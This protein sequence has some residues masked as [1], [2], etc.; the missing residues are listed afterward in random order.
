MRV[1]A[2]LAVASLMSAAVLAEEALQGRM[3]HEGDK[4]KSRSTKYYTDKFNNGPE[5]HGEPAEFEGGYMVGAILGFLFTGIF[6]VFAVINSLWDE[7]KRHKFYEAKIRSDQQ[8]LQENYNVTP[9][10]IQF[11]IRE[12]E[13]K[14]RT[15]GVKKD[16]A[17][18]QAELAEI[19]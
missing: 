11:F 3:L 13:E 18:E 19:N 9:A 2:M 17:A 12:F 1:F 10:D 15:R 8:R 16:T 7:Y 6:M 4:T 14:E 5:T